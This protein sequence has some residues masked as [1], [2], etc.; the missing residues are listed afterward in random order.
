MVSLDFSVTYFLPAKPWPW[1]RAD[2]LPPYC[3]P[4]SR[5]LLG[6]HGLLWESF[7]FTI[8]EK[9]LYCKQI[10]VLGCIIRS[11][12]STY[13]THSFVRHNIFRA[14]HEHHKKQLHICICISVSTRMS[15]VLAAEEEQDFMSLEEK[16]SKICLL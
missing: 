4:L 16:G 10:S 13:C 6:L 12:G 9:L 1:G 7:T 5:N 8:K 14:T 2:N 3:A 11:L 15:L